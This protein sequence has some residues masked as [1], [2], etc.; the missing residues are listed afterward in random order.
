[1]HFKQPNDLEVQVQ[2]VEAEYKAL[3][4]KLKE[5]S[6]PPHGMYETF[7][8]KYM[9]FRALGSTEHVFKEV[10]WHIGHILPRP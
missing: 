6:R 5:L 8:Y 4:V 10:V 9:V 7:M 2:G 3:L 1:M